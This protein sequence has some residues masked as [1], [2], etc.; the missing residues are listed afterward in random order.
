MTLDYGAFHESL[1]AIDTSTIPRGGTNISGAIQAAQAALRRRPGSDKILISGDG[2]RGSRGRRAGCGT[3]GGQADGLKIYTVGVGTAAGD[4]IP[5]PPE[6]G[7][8]FVKDETGAF[9]KSRLDEQG[10]KAIAGATGG[11]YVPLGAQG[12]GV[13]M[14]F[15]NGVSAPSR[16]MIWLRGSRRSTSSAINGRWPRRWRCCWAVF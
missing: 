2:R 11:I 9:V 12:E 15:Q 1:S 6:Q 10:L 8:G 4:L 3:G 7:G 5:I 16:S 13:E 14:I